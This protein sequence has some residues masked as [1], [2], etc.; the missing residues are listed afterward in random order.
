MKGTIELYCER[1]EAEG[2]CELSSGSS[3]EQVAA[4]RAAAA[5]DKVCHIQPSY[6]VSQHPFTSIPFDGRAVV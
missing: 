4:D 2:P 1:S 5:K 3:Q 6:T